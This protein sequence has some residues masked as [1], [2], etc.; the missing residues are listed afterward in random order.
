MFKLRPGIFKAHPDSGETIIGR[1]LPHWPEVKRIAVAAH[2][3]FKT[4]P[5][6]GWDIAITEDG[7][8]IVEGNSQWGTDGVQMSHQKPLQATSIPACLAQ[9]F[10]RLANAHDLPRLTGRFWNPS[11]AD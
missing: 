6:I 10:D 1:T 11:C 7:P 2:E 5:S 3:E 9:H 8:V 4:L